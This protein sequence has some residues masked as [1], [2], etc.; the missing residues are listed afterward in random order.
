MKEQKKEKRRQVKQMREKCDGEIVIYVLK[1]TTDEMLQIEFNW[2]QL[3][4]F[5]WFTV[6]EALR[7]A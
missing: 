4:F 1:K 7:R 6:E 2:N 5:H 3:F